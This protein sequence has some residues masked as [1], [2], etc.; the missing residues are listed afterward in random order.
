MVHSL[1]RNK[2]AAP[3]VLVKYMT[4]CHVICSL[5]IVSEMNYK[6]AAG[7]MKQVPTHLASCR[8]RNE[9]ISR[10]NHCSVSFNIG[11]P[12]VTEYS[13]TAIDLTPLLQ[14][15]KEC[16]QPIEQTGNE[17][18]TKNFFKKFTSTP[19]HK[20]WL[21]SQSMVEN[22]ELIFHRNGICEFAEIWLAPNICVPLV[23]C[24][25]SF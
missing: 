17:K 7:N 12:L 13:E 16:T 9:L 6:Q 22:L 25:V 24:Q 21:A 11:P 8:N 18:Q 10:M 15:K 2:T 20:I 14:W 19:L 5:G 1:F 4:K 3:Q 23:C